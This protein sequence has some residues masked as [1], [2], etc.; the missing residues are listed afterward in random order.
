MIKNCYC[1]QADK[2]TMRL[3]MPFGPQMLAKR[4]GAHTPQIL[5]K[6]TPHTHTQTPPP[7]PIFPSS[8]HSL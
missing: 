8:T 4:P 5:K 7:P 6:T 3:S 1:M 2:E